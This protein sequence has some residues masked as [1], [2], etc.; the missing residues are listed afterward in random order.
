MVAG[1]FSPK[2]ILG[3]IG[4]D[5]SYHMVLNAMHGLGL[6][7]GT[8]LI[9]TFGP[10]GYL[11]MGGLP[12]IGYQV[13]IINSLILS[14][15]LYFTIQLPNI[16]KLNKWFLIAAFILFGYWLKSNKLTHTLFIFL[17]PSLLFSAYIFNEKYR[18]SRFEAQAAIHVLTALIAIVSLTKFSFFVLGFLIV[19]LGSSH[20][21]IVNKT[22]PLWLG[23]YCVVIFSAW[24]ILDQ[25]YADFGTFIYGSYQ[26][27]SA[28]GSALQ[29]WGGLEENILLCLYVS[30]SSILYLILGRILF[31]QFGYK[32]IFSISAWGFILLI[33]LKAGFVRY[34]YS[35]V[36]Q[37]LGILL[38][39]SVVSAIAYWSCNTKRWERVSLL[40]VIAIQIVA[41]PTYIAYSTKQSFNPF[42]RFIS[43]VQTSPLQFYNSAIEKFDLKKLASNNKIYLDQIK[44]RYPINFEEGP[45]DIF[46]NN[47]AVLLANE[48][49]YRP[50]LSF[51]TINTVTPWL[52]KRNAQN[53]TR[54]DA[55]NRLLFTIEPFDNLIPTL[56]DTYSWVQIFSCY[57]FIGWLQEFALLGRNQACRRISW[58]PK[59]TIVGSFGNT[60]AVTKQDGMLW[61]EIEIERT[62]IGKLLGF[63][64]KGSKPDIDIIFDD[65]SSFSGKLPVEMAA[66]GFL[67]SPFVEGT[68]QFVTLLR[69]L[70]QNY[71][72][73]RKVTGI[74]VRV[75]RAGIEFYRE[76]KFNFIELKLD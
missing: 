38:L 74:K 75:N 62:L 47:Q 39:T 53:L 63:I 19:A 22:A 27:A 16:K 71:D 69:S 52:N 41:I 28:Y 21:I 33:G 34:S 46:S 58:G 64:Y 4:V 23:T 20:S 26:I 68:P 37:G 66:G 29:L 7:S 25:N 12:S 11:I 56:G 13:L 9:I 14:L 32:F 48:V 50:R 70:N 55:P 67:L 17:M 15:V 65:G 2:R 72:G 31:R 60:I 24:G 51:Q 30:C 61:V 5:D 45:Y 42:S 6:K 49:S 73:A 18:E 3:E 40:L 35:H 10:L 36:M 59:T 8:D 43:T 54:F 57:R 44:A 1:S 76:V